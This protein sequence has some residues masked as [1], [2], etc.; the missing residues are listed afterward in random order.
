M[1]KEKHDTIARLFSWSL[2]LKCTRHNT[3]RTLKQSETQLRMHINFIQYDQNPIQ[4]TK[5]LRAQIFKKKHSIK[6]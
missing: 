1:N 6:K 3:R 2:A 5:S 4:A